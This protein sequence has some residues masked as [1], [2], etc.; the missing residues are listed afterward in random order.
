MKIILLFFSCLVLSQEKVSNFLIE[1]QYGLY[2]LENFQRSNDESNYLLAFSNNSK[3]R[4]K[5]PKTLKLLKFDSENNYIN[6]NELKIGKDNIEEQYVFSKNV[7]NDIY[8]NTLYYKNKYTLESSLG[9]IDFNT[10]QVKELNK[11]TI[12]KL[13]KKH[14]IIK[15]D[16]QNFLVDLNVENQMLSVYELDG[17]NHSKKTFFLEKEIL[18]HLK[19]NF[20]YY[21]SF[22]SENKSL[23]DYQKAIIKL[24]NDKKKLFFINTSP[25]TSLIQKFPIHIVDFNLENKNVSYKKIE[26]KKGSN[27]ITALDILD[28]DIYYLEKNYIAEKEYNVFT[29]A[30]SFNII[31]FNLNTYEKDFICNLNKK[32]VVNKDLN[33]NY[34]DFDMNPKRNKKETT[35][36]SNFFRYNTHSFKISKIDTSD[37]LIHIATI[38]WDSTQNTYDSMIVSGA[39]MGGALGALIVGGLSSSMVKTPISPIPNSIDKLPYSKGSNL[40]KSYAKLDFI[41][42][43]ES[44]KIKASSEGLNQNTY[45][46]KILKNLKLFTKELQYRGVYKN[47]MHLFFN[48]KEGV[49]QIIDFK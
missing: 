29:E 25:I 46:N 45:T 18:K 22:D 20:D 6:S 28:D 4:S 10:Y 37:Y 1:N 33:L 3:T 40:V 2:S 47:K 16:N 13:S 5:D 17:E 42:D 48:K 44:K 27:D 21:S 32:D 14:K 34:H 36:Y 49:F 26:A 31:K 24:S 39:V 8:L 23:I 9:V 11:Y 35:S 30:E 41:F 43:S 12:D 38:N 15:L 19:K 7:E